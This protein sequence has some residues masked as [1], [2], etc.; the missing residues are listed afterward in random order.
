MEPAC[1]GPGYT[2]PS[3]PLHY[4]LFMLEGCLASSLREREREREF[5]LKGN[6]RDVSLYLKI[7]TALSWE[8]S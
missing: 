6:V 3:Q 5:S 1:T 4:V 2:S 7:L 8:V